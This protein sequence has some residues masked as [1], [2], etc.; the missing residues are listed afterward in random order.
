MNT[1]L[2]TAFKLFRKAA[3]K[4]PAYKAFLKRQHV[5]ADQIKSPNDFTTLP[6]MDKKNYLHRYQYRDLFVSGK[7]PPMAYASSGSSGKP[8]FWFRGDEQEQIGGDI[9][10]KIFK[11]IFRIKKNE[12]T[13][14]VICFSMG[15][16][17][18]GNYTAAACRFLARKGYLLTVITPG[19][20]KTDVFNTLKDLAPHYKNIVL[21]GYPPFLMDMIN[22][23]KTQKISL[24][25]KLKI[26]TAG[27]KFSEAWRQAI[28]E[29]VGIRDYY[30][31]LVSIYGSA[32][33]GVLGFETP[34]SIFLRKTALTN[35][36]LYRDLF[37]TETVLP[38]LVQYDPQNIFFEQAEGEL[39]F[40]TA[41]SAP[42]IRYN[43]HDLGRIITYEQIKALLIK[44]HLLKA[45]KPLGLKD[46]KLP[47]VVKTERTDVAVT[48]YAL[49]IFPE[50]ILAGIKDQKVSKFLSGNFFAYNKQLH[51]NKVQKLY[52]KLELAEGL[53]KLNEKNMSLIR[54]TVLRYLIALNMEFRKL[55]SAIGEKALPVV[56]FSRFH[57]KKFATSGTNG[58]LNI[59]GKKP[60]ILKSRPIKT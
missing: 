10:E 44:Y 18:A 54:D 7:I 27:D 6:L 40:T 19:I 2:T 28:F 53:K 9:H 34:L 20:E 33:A 47:F 39:V 4:V 49:N 56:Y 43:I 38:A 1:G 21:A 29:L 23:C 14:V 15:L 32:D 45:G 5:R 12:P 3:S 48:F 22:D 46:W 41:T 35:K 13:L 8:T 16:W 52:L 25:R 57:D 31:S 37:G 17:I 26:L 30:H 50:H 36:S 24:N 42:L 11:K 60:K 51:H 59:Q 58:I 55:F